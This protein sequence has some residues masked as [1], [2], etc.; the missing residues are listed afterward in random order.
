MATYVAEGHSIFSPIGINEI[1][2][3]PMNNLLVEAVNNN[4]ERFIFTSSQPRV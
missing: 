1:N 2:L 3:I 4:V